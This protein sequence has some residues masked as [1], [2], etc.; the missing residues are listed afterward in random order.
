MVSVTGMTSLGDITLDSAQSVILDGTITSTHNV[1]VT[2]DADGQRFYK[3][4]P[5][6]GVGRV[7]QLVDESLV[8]VFDTDD[9]NLQPVLGIVAHEIKHG[10]T[11][12]A[13]YEDSEGNVFYRNVGENRFYSWQAPNGRYTLQAISNTNGE[14]EL[15]FKDSPVIG[16]GNVYDSNNT[17]VQHPE[18][19]DLLPQ[20]T[21]ITDAAFIAGLTAVTEDT[22]AGTVIFDQGVVSARDQLSIEAQAEI[23]GGELALVLSGAHGEIDL[24]AGGDSTLNSDVSANQRGDS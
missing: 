16:A 8:E 4:S 5:E 14:T 1:H 19:L 6:S 10:L 24:I 9:L 22:T 11:G 2:A 23:V 7:F 13:L 17:Q 18:N 21:E 12:L 20:Y 3:E 15:F